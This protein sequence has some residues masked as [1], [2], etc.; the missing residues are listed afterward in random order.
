MP[1]LARFA[2]PW[3][4]APAPERERLTTLAAWGVRLTPQAGEDR[5]VP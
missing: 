2:R 1:K 5:F 4:N 3:R